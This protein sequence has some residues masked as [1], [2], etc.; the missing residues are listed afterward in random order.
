MKKIVLAFDSFKGSVS[1][2]EISQFVTSHLQHT[3]PYI[4]VQ[5]LVIADGGE[6]T[7]D[8]IAA[9]I[10]THEQYCSSYDPLSREIITRYEIT[11]DGKTAIIELARTSGLPLLSKEERNPLKTSTYGTGVVILDA[12]ERGCTNLLLGIGGSAT[13]DAGMGILC[14]LGIKFYNI[15]G[16]LLSPCGENLHSIA[17]IDT[18]QLS[19]LARKANFTIACDV[20]NPFYG[21]NGPAYIYSPQK[22]AD[23]NMVKML[24]DGLR[25]YSNIINRVFGVDISSIPGAG[26]AGGVGGGLIPFLSC[27]LKSGIDI[28][29]EVCHFDNMIKDAD[30]IFTGE[31]RIDKQTAMGKA[32]G[33][34][35]KHAKRYH[36]PVV[37]LGGSIENVEQLNELGFTT[38]LSIQQGPLTLEEAMQPNTALNS[39]ANTVTQILRLKYGD[40]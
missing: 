35:V 27:R 14:A 31:G 3:M 8:A 34:I 10:A 1:S 16:E 30:L 15:N 2:K 21:E 4:E 19:P 24:D 36:I 26:A 29:M 37:A 32:L 38:V 39:I 25:H 7:S 22:G 23:S 40:Y 5:S 33:G 28:V 17:Q 6:G 18:S 12:L 9:S 20:E 11:D 13:N